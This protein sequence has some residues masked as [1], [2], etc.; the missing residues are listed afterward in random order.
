MSVTTWSIRSIDSARLIASDACRQLLE[1]RRPLPQ[2]FGLPLDLLGLA[3]QLDEDRHL[4]RRTSG[5]DG[6]EDV[7][8]GAERV[9]AGGVHLVADTR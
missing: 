8:D 7:V 3:E 1:L 5:I 2:R 4:R 6:R 9:A